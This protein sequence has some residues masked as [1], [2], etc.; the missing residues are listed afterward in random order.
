MPNFTITLD[1]A[2]ASFYGHVAE[3]AGLPQEQVLSDALYKL[4]GELSLEAL[5]QKSARA[6]ERNNRSI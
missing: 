5:H 1:A 3:Y 6:Q 4:A 2:T